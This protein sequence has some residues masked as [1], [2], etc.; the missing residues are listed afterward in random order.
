MLLFFFGGGGGGGGGGLGV[1]VWYHPYLVS[2][3]FGVP[4]SRHLL[5]L[6]YHPSTTFPSQLQTGPCLHESGLVPRKLTYK[7]DAE[8]LNYGIGFTN[9]VPRTTRGANELSRY[10]CVCGW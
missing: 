8:C 9:I 7:E 10:V 1:V 3:L 4:L 6:V 2:L 5:S